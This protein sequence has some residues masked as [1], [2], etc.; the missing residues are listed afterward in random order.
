MADCIRCIH[1]ILEQTSATNARIIG[2]DCRECDEDECKYVSC[3]S[4]GVEDGHTD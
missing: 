3:E 4:E 2:C 1:A